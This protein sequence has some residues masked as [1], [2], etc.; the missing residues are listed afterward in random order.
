MQSCFYAVFLAFC[1][2]LRGIVKRRGSLYFEI[3]VS[4]CIGFEPLLLRRIIAAIVE[5]DQNLDDKKLWNAYILSMGFLLR[6]TSLFESWI[7]PLTPSRQ[8]RPPANIGGFFLHYLRQ[9]KLPFFATLIVGGLSALLEAIFFYYI[10]R[11]VDILD[12]ANLADGWSGLFAGHGIELA[13]MVG[14]VFVGRFGISVVG[15]LLDE[16]VIGLGF[17]NLV[18]WQSYQHVAQQSLNF[19]NNQHSGSVATKVSQAGGALGD[20]LVG[21]IQ[22]VWTI[23]IFT[24]TTLVLF[25]QLDWRLAAVIIA[26]IFAFALL[27]RFFLPRMRARASARAEASAALNGRVVDSYTNIQTVKL[28]GQSTDNDEYVREGFSRF[29]DATL[30]SGRIFVG[31]R[32]AM[33][34]LSGFMIVAIGALSVQLWASQA[35]TVGAV[36]FTLALALRLNMWL[37]R[38]MGGLSGLMRNFGVVQNAMETISLPLGVVDAPGALDWT[39][40]IGAISFSNVSFQYAV[41]QDVIENLNLDIAPGEKIGLVGRSG[42][43]KTTVANLLLRFYD[44]DSGQ[45]LIDGQDISLVKQD[46]LRKGIGV[47]TQDSALLHRSIRENIMYGRPHADEGEMI[48]AAKR[49]SIHDVIIGVKDPSGRNGYD[50]R[51]GERGVKLSGGQRQRIAIARVLLKDA[52]ILV[53]DEATSAL[54][55]EIEAAIQEE[56]T[57]LMTDKTVIAI[58]HRLSTIAAMDRLVILDKGRVVEQGTHAELLA[59]AGHYAQLWQH[60]SGGFL[61]VG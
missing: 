54:D 6:I 53:L 60:Q 34:L 47:V 27:A 35:I 58:A 3:D 20:F 45:I 42:A 48:N 12:S 59:K 37:G 33:M 50:A 17:Y 21:V 36:A 55:S 31:L 52:P 5:G 25:F 16:Q 41:S 30:Q 44:L 14:V 19:F 4:C 46:A 18:R 23:T 28:F 2:A 10:G 40:D 29:L 38:L 24:I 26:W 61:E 1:N 7:D 32:A 43:G 13:T 15:A 8:L 39:P 49:A 57:G 11:L 56:L 9:A 51:V 22:V